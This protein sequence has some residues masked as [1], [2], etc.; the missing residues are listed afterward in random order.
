MKRERIRYYSDA[1]TDDFAGT[2]IHTKPVGADFPFHPSSIVWRI[3]AFLAY[4][5]V[6]VP[7]VF[8]VS[9]LYLGLRF[10]NRR[11]LHKLRG[12]GFYL[13]GNHT[14][15]LDAF[16]PAMAAFPSKAY[17]IANPDAVSLPLLRTVVQ[18]LG[19]IPVPT[20][21]AGMR[22]FT[23]AVYARRA[24]GNCIAIYPEAHIWPF[25]TGIRPFP[26][27][28]FRYPVR[29]GAPVVAMVTTY[30]KREG[31]FRFCARPGM[32]ITFSEPMTANPTLP[33]K[34]A[35]AELRD[36]VRAFM[37]EVSSR[38]ENVAFIRYIPLQ[39]SCEPKE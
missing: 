27:T 28:S 21:L 29:D 37:L 6:A 16:V 23:D 4:Y 18:M 1:S 14:Q 35:Q 7:I 11:V 3:V 9:K 36:R 12:T 8:L 31:L 34:K 17:I 38:N 39:G 2:N 5:L 10:E 26:D 22:P 25:Y 13:Y 32:T 30:R 19:A 24:E 15:Q 33:P 20:E